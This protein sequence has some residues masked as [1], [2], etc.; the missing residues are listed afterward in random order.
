MYTLVRPAVVVVVV[1]RS[2]SGLAGMGGYILWT[3]QVSVGL[4]S[5]GVAN[6]KVERQST[7]VDRDAA[8]VM[9]GEMGQ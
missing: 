7:E 4:R 5:E 2:C 9:S 3:D 8:V 1:A 6:A